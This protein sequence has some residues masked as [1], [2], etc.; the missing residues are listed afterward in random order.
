MKQITYKIDCNFCGGT[1][2]YTIGNKKR[3]LLCINCFGNGYVNYTIDYIN[4]FKGLKKHPLIK[5]IGKIITVEGKETIE[6][7]D[8]NKWYKEKK[9]KEGERKKR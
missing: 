1:G 7:I 4:P 9:M 8:Y 5:C 6:E 2:V 3:G